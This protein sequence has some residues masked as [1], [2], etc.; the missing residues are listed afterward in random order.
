[1]PCPG[2][3]HQKCTDWRWAA[4]AWKG[5]VDLVFYP[6]SGAGRADAVWEVG[7]STW[8]LLSVT[9]NAMGKPTGAVAVATDPSDR[10]SFKL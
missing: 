1:M 4:V 9:F 10:W 5:H 6:E 2:N 3:P 7:E 8:L